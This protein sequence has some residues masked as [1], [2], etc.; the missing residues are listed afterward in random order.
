MRKICFFAILTFFAIINVNAAENYFSNRNGVSLTKEEYDFISKI[1][2]EGYQ[3]D[4]KEEEYNYIFTEDISNFS[5]SEISE[6]VPIQM[7]GTSI[8]TNS[9]SLKITKTQGTG[10]ALISIVA[11]WSGSPVVRSYDV[12]GAYLSNVSLMGAPITKVTSSSGTTSYADVRYNGNGFGVSVKLPNSGS[13]IIVSQ[14]FKV[15][16]NGHVYGSYQ[17]AKNSVTQDNSKNYTISLSGYGNVFNFSNSVKNSY[18]QMSG[19]DI[20][21]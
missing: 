7:F 16:G 19:V 13:G 18:D 14:A 2:Y 5:E 17:H 21:V 6:Y 11:K 1:F 8:T 9:K 20:A 15:T 4:L 10:Y 3:D 12:I